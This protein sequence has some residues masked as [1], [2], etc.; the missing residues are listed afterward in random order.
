MVTRCVTTG[1][2]LR[3]ENLS[4]HLLQGLPDSLYEFTK[5]HVQRAALPADHQAWEL[6][7]PVAGAKHKPPGCPEVQYAYR[8]PVPKLALQRALQYP[9]SLPEGERWSRI[10]QVAQTGF[11]K[12]LTHVPEAA[13]CLEVQIIAPHHNGNDQF[14]THLPAPVSPPLRKDVAGS[15]R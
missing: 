7:Q 5:G 8:Y 14:Y 6:T 1:R 13:G 15:S 3:Q 12:H 11:L 4:H 10:G 2:G 9:H